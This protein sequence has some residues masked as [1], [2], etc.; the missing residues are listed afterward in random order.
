MKLFSVLI[1][2]D[3]FGSPEGILCG[4]GGGGAWNGMLLSALSGVGAV[5]AFMGALAPVR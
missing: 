4:C 5:S 1:P 3:V 2:S